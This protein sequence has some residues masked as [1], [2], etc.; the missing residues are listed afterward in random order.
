MSRRKSVR[1]AQI[2]NQ[3]YSRCIAAVKRSSMRMDL[4]QFDK[5]VTAV[6]LHRSPRMV[7]HAELIQSVRA[8]V[9]VN[10]RGARFPDSLPLVGK[11]SAA[12]HSAQEFGSMPMRSL[13]ADRIRCLQPR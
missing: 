7:G 8:F 12:A 6:E 10:L 9:A 11:P 4:N 3:R 13:T 5:P 1:F 2:G